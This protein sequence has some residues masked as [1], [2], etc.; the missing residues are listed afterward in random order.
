MI[1]IYQ[2]HEDYA[3]SIMCKFTL[4]DYNSRNKEGIPRIIV[5]DS[6]SRILDTYLNSPYREPRMQ[7]KTLEK[8]LKKYNLIES[9]PKRS[10][11]REKYPEYLI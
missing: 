2:K 5:D 10:Y 6:F 9:Y 8:R 11:V 1:N 7:I 4:V 3:D